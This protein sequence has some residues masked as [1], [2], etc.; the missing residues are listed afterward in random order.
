VR[1]PC[2]VL[3]PRATVIIRNVLMHCGAKSVAIPLRRVSCAAMRVVWKWKKP[4]SVGLS[5]IPIVLIA[6]VCAD[7][8]RVFGR[9]PISHAHKSPLII[10][11]LLG[12][13]DMSLR[14]TNCLIPPHVIYYIYQT[15]GLIYNPRS[16]NE[17]LQPFRRHPPVRS[18]L[19]ITDT[20]GRDSSPAHTQPKGQHQ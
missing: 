20:R 4:Y 10:H 9:E 3:S 11:V 19:C 2:A 1:A 7:L 17:R 13:W 16:Y 6:S 5:T 8:F 18:P 12:H 15:N 14:V